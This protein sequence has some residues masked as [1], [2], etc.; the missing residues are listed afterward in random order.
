MTSVA[1]VDRAEIVHE[2]PT[3]PLAIVDLLRL[4]IEK[5]IPVEALEKLQALHERVSDRAAAMEYA[6]ALA[7]FQANC[8]PISKNREADYSTGTGIRV[9]YGY[10][11]LD[12]IARTIAPHL[13][14]V[15]LS[16]TW[17]TAVKEK[18]LEIRCTLRHVNGHA[19]VSLFSVPFESKAGMSEQQ[20]FSAAGQFGRRLS[21]INVL[22]LTTTGDPEIDNVDPTTITEQQATD[23]DALIQEVGADK[24]RFLTWA[25]VKSLAEIRVVN[26]DTCVKAVRRHRAR[27]K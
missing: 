1:T 20:K 27:A 5:G 9:R 15:G 16:Y 26:Y 8:P 19:E 11:E 4:A 10:A 2:Q 18:V 6:G 24:M 14:A 7:T 13:R 3:S 25:G 17:D 22:G 12:H 23:L 21:L